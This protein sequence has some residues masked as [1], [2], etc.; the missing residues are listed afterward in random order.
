MSHNS[1]PNK[2]Q[3][4]ER[5][6][7]QTGLNNMMVDCIAVDACPQCENRRLLTMNG[8][9]TGGEVQKKYKPLVCSCCGYRVDLPL[10]PAL[11][12]NT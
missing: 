7:K 3:R 9:C 8:I 11:R 2:P 4:I 1:L 5:L 10:G 6:S 12:S